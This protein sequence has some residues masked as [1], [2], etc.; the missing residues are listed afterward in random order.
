[1]RDLNKIKKNATVI[2]NN[3]FGKIFGETI[4]RKILNLRK[5]GTT[6]FDA[7]DVENNKI[8]LKMSRHMLP[9]KITEETLLENLSA[10]NI[11]DYRRLL[12]WNEI[13]KL[14]TQGIKNIKA[15]D[16]LYYGHLT[17]EGLFFCKIDYNTMRNDKK[18]GSWSD[19]SKGM[20]KS[21][22]YNIDL[23]WDHHW[24]NYGYKYINWVEII[25]TLQN[26]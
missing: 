13:T 2:D 16:I 23:W 25:N 12:S 6:E 24:I 21:F 3:R 26:K 10:D 7:L 20:D 5:S 9:H 15:F 19:K 22:S 8:E 1:M 14:Q 4:Y 11:L 18:L 17:A